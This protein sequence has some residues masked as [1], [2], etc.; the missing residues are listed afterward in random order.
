MGLDP[1]WSTFIPKQT[2]S[3]RSKQVLQMG[4]FSLIG[5]FICEVQFLDTLRQR[6]WKAQRTHGAVLDAGRLPS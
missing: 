2:E 6:S 1:G 3:P 4:L 5:N